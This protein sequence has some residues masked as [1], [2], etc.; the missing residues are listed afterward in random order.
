M[1]EDNQVYKDEKDLPPLKFIVRSKDAVT[2][3]FATPEVK[4][5][6]N[7][8]YP[9]G[10]YME[11]SKDG[12]LLGVIHS[13]QVCIY[14]TNSGSIVQKFE[15]E[16]AVALAFSPLNTYLLTWERLTPEKNNLIL[17]SVQDGQSVAS[18][19]QKNYSSETWPS[20]KWS[21]DEKVCG[22]LVSNQVDFYENGNYIS[23]V[24]QL[25][26]PNVSNFSISPGQVKIAAFVP[27]KKGQPAFVRVFR[28]PQF[29]NHSAS[30]SFFKAQDC[31]FKWNSNGSSLLITTH[32]DV[33]KSGKSYY[34][35]TS[36]YFLSSDGKFDCN[37]AL[38][39]AG[40][41]HDSC[42]SPS[43]KQF[44]VT[45]GFMPSQTTLFDQKCQPV[46]DIGQG[47]RN[48][49]KWSC[50]DKLVCLS[51]F[52]NISGNMEIWDIRKL[53]KISSIPADYASSLDWAPNSHFF[54]T[55]VLFPRMKVD[56]NFKL[57]KYDGSLLFTEKHQ[58]IYQVSWRPS[59]P[60]VY[61]PP[62]AAELMKVAE[63]QPKTVA[64]TGKYV[65]PHLVGKKILPLTRVDDAPTKYTKTSSPLYVPKDQGPPGDF[66]DPPK[67]KKKKKPSKKEEEVE[68]KEE[69]KQVQSQ[70]VVP[71]ETKPTEMNAEK[72]LKLIQKKLRQIDTLK[73]QKANG[74]S[75]DQAAL[76]KIASE[77]QLRKELNEI[78][79]E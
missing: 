22:H 62:K 3:Y 59:A 63:E 18:W 33:D 78:E 72:K 44:L 53:K 66:A 11:F 36:L 76:E 21:D 47:A 73:E 32:V 70:K 27:E 38:K 42:W 25:K 52:G 69:P 43:G 24:Q 6:P 39:Q 77:A 71:Q 49:I 67:K 13:N 19:S 17:W 48:T 16:K 5:D 41:I 40:P 9:P 75:L 58:E 14:N 54:L 56:N 55:G 65:P 35:E 37:V 68:K 64:P 45:Y 57:W 2:G 60:N 28:Y 31:S 74:A 10:N 12:S 1:E 26:L 20:L 50:H 34:G 51:G 29:E 46:A 61:P 4:P 23:I 30:K 8:I 7:M 15:I 79:S